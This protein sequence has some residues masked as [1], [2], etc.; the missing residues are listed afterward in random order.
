MA[1][2]LLFAAF[3]ATLLPTSTP[4]ALAQKAPDPV[5][6]SFKT[7]DGV[8]LRGIFHAS[9]KN[10]GNDPVVIL[11]Y[12]PG[13][14]NSMNKGEWK[15]LANKLATEGYNVFRFDWR[16]HGEKV[17]DIKDTNKF[18]LNP[19]TGP[20]NN[21]YIFGANK[22]PLKNELVWKDFAP[23]GAPAAQLAQNVKKYSPV[24]LTDL[25]AARTHLDQKNDNGEVNTS[26]VY[27]IGAQE[28]AAVGMAW[29]TAEWQRPATHP[30]LGLGQTYQ[31]CPQPGI[32]VATEAGE[33]IAGAVWLTAMRPENTPFTENNLK[34][35]A[36]KLAPKMRENNPML[37]LYGGTDATG[38]RN[39]DFYYNEVL[40]A[41]PKKGSTLQK[42]EQTFSKE[43]KGTNLVGDKLL[44][45]NKELG[46][47]DRMMAFLNEIQKERSKI[48]R[49]KRDYATPYFID[50]TFLGIDPTK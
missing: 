27:L 20:A 32:A 13:K 47:E 5:E 48:T 4:R 2:P 17:T 6:E 12:P 44:G 23:P 43:I 25:A 8:V 50:L 49:K 22:K 24:L 14:D 41:D 31:I 7:A 11:L 16:A 33:T 26:S 34:G 38:K 10:P 40:V 36:S 39:T 42:L 1:A 19:I 28:A 45:N 18:W 37:F 3:A 9:A 21:K 30:V 29:I 46:T 15:A 35:W